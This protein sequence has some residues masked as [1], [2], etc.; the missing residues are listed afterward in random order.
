[1]ER[2]STVYFHNAGALL[3]QLYKL[4]SP[5]IDPRTREKVVFLPTDPREAAAVLAKDIDVAVRALGGSG[6]RC[7]GGGAC[8]RRHARSAF[9]AAIPAW[10]LGL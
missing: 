10:G 8:V 2:L 1:V 7:V 3:L 5:F 6:W 4:V 9:R